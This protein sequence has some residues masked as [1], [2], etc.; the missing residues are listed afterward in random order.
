MRGDSHRFSVATEPDDVYSRVSTPS[1]STQH[2]RSLF[3]SLQERLAGVYQ[4]LGA[5]GADV[6]KFSVLMEHPIMQDIVNSLNTYKA[7]VGCS[8]GL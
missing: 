5:E 6:I 2:Q 3:H 7:L 8:L 4:E 1:L